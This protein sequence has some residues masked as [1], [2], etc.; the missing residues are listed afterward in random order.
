MSIPEELEPETLLQAYC[1]GYF[2]MGGYEDGEI[3][4]FSP[5]ERGIIPLDDRFHI[6][7][8]L[9]RALRKN[10][11]EIRM[12][13]AFAEV[14]NAC[15]QRKEVWID[16]SIKD[17]YCRLHELGVA[18]SVE[19][20]DEDGLQG[21]LYGVSLGL[22]FFGESMFTRKT[23]ASKVALVALVNH[24]RLNNFILLDSQWLTPHLQ[25]FGAREIPRKHYLK[26]LEKALSPLREKQG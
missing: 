25:Q 3:R 10:P 12:D 6:P 11:F 20:W 1:Q 8:G 4:W 22:A 24:L 5:E 14:I 7:H 2:P 15:G 19:A 26:M 21:G 23:D 13:T 18:H 17:A 9:K 16:D